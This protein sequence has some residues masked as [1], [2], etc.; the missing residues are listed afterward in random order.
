[1]KTLTIECPDGLAKDLDSFVK[2]GCATD[3]QETVLEALRK[4]LN[5]HRPDLIRAQALDDVEWGLHGND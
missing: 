5:S 3:T 1:M 2:S 4:F